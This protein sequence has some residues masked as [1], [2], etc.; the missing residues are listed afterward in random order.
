LIGLQARID[1]K[2]IS[3]SCAGDYL[4]AEIS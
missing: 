1:V 2:D 4:K 3:G